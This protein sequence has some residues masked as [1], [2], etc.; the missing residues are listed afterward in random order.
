M[1]GPRSHHGCVCVSMQGF[2][3]CVPGEIS[4]P[5]QSSL[6]ENEEGLVWTRERTRDPSRKRSG[7]IWGQRDVRAL[8]RSRDYQSSSKSS[9][10]TLRLNG[11]VIRGQASA[12]GKSACRVDGPTLA[13]QDMIGWISS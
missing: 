11:G 10:I 5:Q 4:V 3:I 7:L 13:S 1:I 8:T 6:G 2:V 9:L 12:D